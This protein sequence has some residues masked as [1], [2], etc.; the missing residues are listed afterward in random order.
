MIFRP[1]VANLDYL[2]ITFSAKD[3]DFNFD[4]FNILLLNAFYY[5]IKPVI[6]INKVELLTDEEQSSLKEKLSFLKT[7]DID[8]FYVSTYKNINIDQVSSYISG[9]LTAF[10]GPS[11]VGKS[12]LINMLQN[13][14]ELE[15]GETSRKTKRG[16][17][18]TKG[19]TL[20]H[21]ENGG[22]IIDTPG[23]TSLEIPDV[24]DKYELENLF[25]EFSNYEGCKF[26]DCIHINEPECMVKDAVEKGKISQLRYNFYVKIHN[27]LKSERWNRV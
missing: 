9:H 26:S 23:F 8:T 22:Y 18:T 5:N 11:G 24:S 3:P 10:G 20:L 12:S 19:T 2:V 17:H 1:L 27:I 7:L 16:K 21:L 4:G 25:P 14:K 6:V 15:I 13:E